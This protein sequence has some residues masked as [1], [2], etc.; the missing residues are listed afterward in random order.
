M[1]HIHHTITG[2]AYEVKR[3]GGRNPIIPQ[4]RRTAKILVRT[5]ETE[6]SRFIEEQEKSGMSESAFG[7]MLL[8]IGLDSYLSRKTG[9]T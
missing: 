3:R 8:S 4:L 1:Y 6:K 9:K 5:T 7:E 2:E